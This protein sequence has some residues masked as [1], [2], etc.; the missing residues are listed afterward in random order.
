MARPRKKDN[1]KTSSFYIEEETEEKIDEYIEDSDLKEIR[2]RGD[3]IDYFIEKHG[4]EMD[5]VMKFQNLE[6]ENKRLKKENQKLKEKMKKRNDS[7][8][9]LIEPDPKKSFREACMDAGI[10]E[11]EIKNILDNNFIGKGSSN[12]IEKFV[13]RNSVNGGL[14]NWYLERTENTQKYVEYKFKRI[15]EGDN[16]E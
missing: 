16:H 14:E 12:S 4:D 5:L 13:P 10:T 8:I 11:D 2:S 15:E 7:P 3:V 9:E 6:K 1:G